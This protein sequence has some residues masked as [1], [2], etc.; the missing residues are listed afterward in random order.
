MSNG[1]IFLTW[2]VCQLKVLFQVDEPA[3]VNKLDVWDRNWM[4]NYQLGG[5]CKEYDGN[6]PNRQKEITVGWG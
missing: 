3:I 5:Y 4:W 1:E 6:S 2:A